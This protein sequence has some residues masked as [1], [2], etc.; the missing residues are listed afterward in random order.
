MPLSNKLDLAVVSE[1]Y[2]VI[3]QLP[4]HI[5]EFGGV[6]ES[7][8]EIRS[9]NTENLISA[10]LSRRPRRV[11]DL[12]EQFA[13][14]SLLQIQL[15]LARLD[16]RQVEYLVNEFKQMLASAV[17]LVKIRGGLAIAFILGVF[18]QDLTVADHRVQRRSQLVA[19]LGKEFGLGCARQFGFLGGKAERRCGRH[20]LA[21]FAFKLG[22]RSLYFG[23][24]ERH[25][26]NVERR[27]DG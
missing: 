18:K 11:D 12:A 6:A 23:V 2:R 15:H 13:Q 9:Y 20:M 24:V 26:R 8:S 17:N 4:S 19:H 22:L 21:H 10:F 1:F 14:I 3:N 7:S 16:L 27:R 25:H 5:A